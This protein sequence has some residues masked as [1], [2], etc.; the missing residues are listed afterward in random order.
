[1]SHASTTPLCF[2]LPSSKKD[3]QVYRSVDGDGNEYPPLPPQQV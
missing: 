1:L 3:Y 2:K